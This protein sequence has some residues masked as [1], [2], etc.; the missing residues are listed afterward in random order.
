MFKTTHF[1]FDW[2]EF[3]TGIALLIAAVVM[4]RHPGATMLTLSFIFAIIAIIRGIAT[5]AA[6]SKLHE[7]TGVRAWVSLVAGII[8]LLVGVL[9]L[10]DLESGVMALAYFFATW[11]LIDSIANLLN[12][13]HLRDAGLPW[14]ILN[15]L[16][17]LLA[18]LISLLLFMQPVLSAVGIVTILAMFVAVWGVNAL[19]LAFG[20]R[21]L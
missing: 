5:L 16:F 19:V 15:I 1:G 20:R 3:I 13:S 14:L 18:I 21:Y 11:F 4:L 7:L 8:D 6:F 10:F 2:G 17:D 9:F 12:A